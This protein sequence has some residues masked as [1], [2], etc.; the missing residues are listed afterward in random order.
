[1]EEEEEDISGNSTQ[2]PFSE[3]DYSDYDQGEMD[4]FF[5]NSEDSAAI[6]RQLNQ[7]IEQEEEPQ[8]LEPARTEQT[9]FASSLEEEIKEEP[10]S[11]QDLRKVR[12]QRA[13]K[14]QV[15]PRVFGEPVEPAGSMHEVMEIDKDF[16]NF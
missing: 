14:R 3:I 1:M 7:D 9:L 12:Q 10:E 13:R 15:R 11:E 8:K 4:R 2:M 5:N 6:F 16:S